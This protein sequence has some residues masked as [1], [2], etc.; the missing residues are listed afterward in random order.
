MA[1]IER[2]E[3]STPS[4]GDPATDVVE[5]T[6]ESEEPDKSDITDEQIIEKLNNPSP[7][8]SEAL[9]AIV[10]EEVRKA[11]ARKSP[12]RSTTQAKPITK[13]KFDRM[14]YTERLRLYKENRPLYE[15]LV[16]G[17]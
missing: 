2:E 11:I 5:L 1:E 3:P 14:T 15:V 7:A 8:V 12:R 17:E 16:K 6:E 13:E 4:Y 10:A 9:K